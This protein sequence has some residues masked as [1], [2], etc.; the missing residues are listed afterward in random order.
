MNVYVVAILS[1]LLLGCGGTKTED[2]ELIEC[3]GFFS[4]GAN[5]FVKSAI[6]QTIISNATVVVTSTS[7]NATLV[8]Q[9]LYVA[10]DDRLT[11][12]EDY[13]YYT[14]LEMNESHWT[15][16]YVVSAPGYD[17]V[18]SEDYL[19]T[20]YTSCGARNSFTAEVLLCPTGTV[21]G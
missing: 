8:E 1:L 18:T 13:A 17:T 9:A 15:L 5:I 6:D 16:N 19:I 21:C 2:E 3:A 14:N 10:G 7:D 20:V 11:N 4:P 12:S